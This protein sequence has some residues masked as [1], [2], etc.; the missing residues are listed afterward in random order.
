MNMELKAVT[1]ELEFNRELIE[2]IVSGILEIEEK[3]IHQV[4]PREVHD[5]ILKLVRNLLK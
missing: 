2:Q 1:K 3:K 5:D 4:Q